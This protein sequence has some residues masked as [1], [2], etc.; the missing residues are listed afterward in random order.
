MTENELTLEEYQAT[1]LTP[2]QIEAMQGHN[3]AL[4]EQ[5][6]DY[7]AIGT[8]EEFR[9]AVERQKPKKPVYV[10]DSGIRYTDMYRC[11]HCEKGFTGTG[12]A[13]FCYH[14]GQALDFGEE[15]F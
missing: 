8:V 1:G 6:A 2:E 3:V 15:G 4:I 11:P 5:L 12:I 14:C 10:N 7:Q 9:S 13:H